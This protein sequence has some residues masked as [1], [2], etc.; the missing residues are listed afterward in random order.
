MIIKSFTVKICRSVQDAYRKRKTE[1]MQYSG[2][3]NE[4]KQKQLNPLEIGKK[5]IQSRG[6]AEVI[7]KEEKSIVK[8]SK[9]KSKEENNT[10]NGVVGL[11]NQLPAPKIDFKNLVLFLIIIGD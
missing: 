11:E 3:L 2:I 4:I 10:P 5:T 1:M 9:E 6:L 8:E 7:R